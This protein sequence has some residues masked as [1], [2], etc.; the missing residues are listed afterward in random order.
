MTKIN[1]RG[2][3]R[4]LLASDSRGIESFRVGKVWKLT[5]LTFIHTQETEKALR[6]EGGENRK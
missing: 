4:I 6:K 2:K 5:D 3:K 1:V